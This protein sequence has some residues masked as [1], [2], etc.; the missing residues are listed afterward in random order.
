VEVTT[1][2]GMF[3]GVAESVDADGAL[4]LRTPSGALRRLLA[5]DVTLAR[6]SDE[7]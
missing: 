6:R 1:S 4:L 2:E 3:K 7:V 5:G